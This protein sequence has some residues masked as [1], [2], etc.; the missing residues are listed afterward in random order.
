M[1]DIVV[2]PSQSESF[3]Y[4][5]LESL[6]L[7]IPTIMNDIPTFKEI[8]IGNEAAY[9]FRADAKEL[10]GILERLLSDPHR[11]VPNEAW[12]HRYALQS[13]VA[14]YEELFV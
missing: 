13:W 7:G 3:G 9:F 11:K 6:T 14:E 4:A 2:L 5:A 8:A 12:V 1:T 10:A